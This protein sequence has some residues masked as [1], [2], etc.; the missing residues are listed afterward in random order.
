MDYI[1]FSL[2]DYES[3]NATLSRCSMQIKGELWACRLIIWYYFLYTEKS[4][5][6]TKN[7][8]KAGSLWKTLCSMGQKGA[9][10]VEDKQNQHGFPENPVRAGIPYTALAPDLLQAVMIVWTFCKI[11]VVASWC[12]AWWSFIGGVGCESAV[13]WAC[14]LNWIYQ[15]TWL[16]KVSF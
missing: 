4:R 12:S 15:Q 16:K 9:W 8:R 11:A 3:C 7:D 13:L 1:F 14:F 10:L 6:C 2:R 5:A